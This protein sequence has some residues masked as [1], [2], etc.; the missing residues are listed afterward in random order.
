M[1]LD[2]G[3]LI[4]KVMFVGGHPKHPLQAVVAELDHAATAAAHEM[5]MFAPVVGRLIPLEPFAEV[6]LPDQT[7]LDQGFDGSVERR[8]SNRLAPLRQPPPENVDRGMIQA[9]EQHFG[10]HHPLPGDR[11]P[12]V[13]EIAPE[14]IDQER[15]VSRCRQ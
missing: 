8:Q 9:V 14:P 4:L 2:P 5:G 12:P 1:D 6:V 10:H 11:E 15:A 13:P 7:A 3:P